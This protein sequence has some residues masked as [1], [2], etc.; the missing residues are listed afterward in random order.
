M[1]YPLTVGEH[2]LWQT[3]WWLVGMWHAKA[4]LSAQIIRLG[5][6]GKH[7]VRAGERAPGSSPLQRNSKGAFGIEITSPNAPT[8]YAW[9]DCCRSSFADDF[10]GPFNQRDKDRGS[11]KT[12][13]F[14]SEIGFQNPTGS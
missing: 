7:A 8:T 14:A 10:V 1:R 6:A 11:G 13:I 2:H 9:R 3:T 4:A 12:R 5:V